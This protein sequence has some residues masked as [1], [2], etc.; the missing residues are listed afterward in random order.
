M[1]KFAWI[2]LVLVFSCTVK[3]ENSIADLKPVRK[4]FTK[5]SCIDESCAKVN[6]SWP[7][8]VADERGAR[9]NNAVQGHLISY[10]YQDAE[11]H[12]DSQAFNL[13]QYWEIYQSNFEEAHKEMPQMA[14]SWELEVKAEVT[15]DSL[16]TI[17]V[18]FT[19]YD[20]S[21]GAHPNS[22]EYF[23]NFDRESGKYL[24]ADQLIL[25][26]QKLLETAEGAFREFH[27]VDSELS[28]KEDG[29]F[30]LSESDF[31]LPA[32]MGFRAD[33]FQLI[34]IPYEIGPYAMGYTQ[35]EFSL[36]QVKG[37]VRM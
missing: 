22:S 25:D 11:I 20:Y 19:T 9:L 10:F 14:G 34:Y 30:F 13:E 21:G 32:A 16:N 7:E 37:I 5:E 24:P 8:F 2:L 6:F 31:F 26:R 35:L 15:F 17:S 29:R 28:L 36:D 23:M 33:H 12:R 4:T 1:N 3:N 27:E 18:F